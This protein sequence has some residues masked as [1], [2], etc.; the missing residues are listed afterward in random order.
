MFQTTEHS[1]NVDHLKKEKEKEKEKE[2]KKKI[3]SLSLLFEFQLNR[4]QFSQTLKKFF[5][6]L[7]DK[8]EGKL[9][10]SFLR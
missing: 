4:N 6:H 5:G 8:A 3:L 7:L 9:E 2:K 10:Q 1:Y